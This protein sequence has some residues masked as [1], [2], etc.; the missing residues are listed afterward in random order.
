MT[1]MPKKGE[2]VSW[3]TAQG[4]TEGT[5]EKTVTG[6]AKIKG[7]TARATKEEPQLIVKS[8]KS[9]K[10]AAHKPDELKKA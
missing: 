9:G 5:V 1:K 4:R 2:K 6:T 3:G 8:A 7:H 10:Q